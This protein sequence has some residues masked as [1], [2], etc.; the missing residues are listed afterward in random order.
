[1]EHS[2]RLS[3]ISIYRHYFILVLLTFEYW[4]QPSIRTSRL[5]VKRN[6]QIPHFTSSIFIF[7]FFLLSCLAL[8]LCSFEIQFRFAFKCF[9]AHTQSLQCSSYLHHFTFASHLKNLFAVCLC[10]CAIEL[11][12]SSASTAISRLVWLISIYLFYNIARAKLN[13]RATFQQLEHARVRD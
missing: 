13:L 9:F 12:I 2:H 7:A 6:Q 4:T 3:N 10:T 1:M 11:F 5:S 8:N